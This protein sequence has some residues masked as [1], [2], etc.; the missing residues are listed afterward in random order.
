VSPRRDL[1][2][3]PNVPSRAGAWL[4]FPGEGRRMHRDDPR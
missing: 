2:H 3:K 4:G 1:P